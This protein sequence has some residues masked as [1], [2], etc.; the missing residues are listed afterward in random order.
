MSARPLRA[1]PAPDVSIETITPEKA[2]KWLAHNP[3]N[4][5]LA[6]A[7]F[8]AFAAAVLRNEWR[9]HGESIKF[10]LNG[11]LL[12]GQHRLAAVVKSGVTIQSVVVRGVPRDDQKTID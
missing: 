6:D 3:A 12:D 5:N 1:M 4:R 10:D 9:L 11:D 2:A 8:G 7:R